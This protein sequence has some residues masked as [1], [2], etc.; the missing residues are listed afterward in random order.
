MSLLFS[1]GT[2][3]NSEVRAMTGMSSDAQPG[4][5]R[6]FLRSWN[7]RIEKESRTAL[8]V[9]PKEGS[10]VNGVACEVTEEEL[11]KFDAREKGYIRTQISKNNVEGVNQDVWMYIPDN[12][13]IA[14]EDYPVAQTYIDAAIA[15]CLE[16]S[17]DFATEFIKTTENWDVPI[18]HDREQPIY[19]H[20]LKHVDYQKID[21][22]LKSNI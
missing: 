6:G 11:K 20:A 13:E 3:M 8:G 4:Y 15:G 22:I 19:S 5:V 9:V 10:R 1:Y 18:I 14:N 16:I 2:L 21:S 12:T 7:V 17:E